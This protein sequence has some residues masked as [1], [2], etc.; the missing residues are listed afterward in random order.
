M[1]IDTW[2]MQ[3]IILNAGNMSEIKKKCTV[4]IHIY[5]ISTKEGRN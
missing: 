4:P 2:N 5:R 1:F 3:K